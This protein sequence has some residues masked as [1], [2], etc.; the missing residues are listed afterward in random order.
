MRAGCR[1]MAIAGLAVLTVGGA[2]AEEADYPCFGEV[3][4]LN[5]DKAPSFGVISLLVPPLLFLEA[6]ARDELSDRPRRKMRLS[7]KGSKSEGAPF[8]LAVASEGERYLGDL[9]DGASIELPEGRHVVLAA[10]VESDG[11]VA[12]GRR[13]ITVSE[14]GPSWLEV[15]VDRRTAIGGALRVTQTAPDGRAPAGSVVRVDWS[16]PWQSE[17]RVGFTKAKSDDLLLAPVRVGADRPSEI[18]VPARP[19]SY[20][21]RLD[22]CAP[23]IPLA[24]LPIEV[25]AADVRLD[26]P[27]KVEAGSAFQVR[28]LG[29]NGLDFK[30]ALL[31]PDGRESEA[32][33]A[34][35][36]EPS[37]EF[38]APIEPGR[39]TLVRRAGAGD[40]AVET[41]RRTIEVTATAVD[42]RAPERI[43]VG[44]RVAID[45]TGAS[46]ATR[47]ELWSLG[48]DGRSPRRV[49]ERV[50]HGPKVRIPAGAGAWE[51]RLVSA[52]GGDTVLAR[53]RLEVE[54]GLFTQAPTVSKP[55][56]HW[57]VGLAEEGEFFDEVS[58]VPRGA[59]VEAIDTWR[60]V[61]ANGERAIDVVAPEKP[62][63]W[64]LL[65]VSGEP[66]V[67]P[68]ILD[69]RGFDVV[70]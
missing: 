20:R 45:W 48:R 13:E 56:E 14:K 16:G 51:L 5:Y 9:A 38:T 8:R 67:E 42:I 61:R 52:S 34:T 60:T 69:R 15:T 35:L 21:L 1:T 4:P 41:A 12:W 6:A 53:R 68:V 37:A 17:A 2:R 29:R 55:G 18:E 50:D 28:S 43:R 22:L 33:D 47:L 65:I 64:D 26:A 7:V 46:G 30:M 27:A 11:A 70:K 54:G 62:G 66:A 10:R 40:A 59:G 63:A 57:A 24:W 39:Y 3:R 58:I 31:A 25:S 19:G 49:R 23:R 44:S 36:A 32:H